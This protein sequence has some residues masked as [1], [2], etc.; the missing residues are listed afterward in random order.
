MTQPFEERC[1]RINFVFFSSQTNQTKTVMASKRKRQATNNETNET[2]DTKMNLFRSQNERY[3][4][5]HRSIDILISNSSAVFVRISSIELSIV[6][7]SFEA[8]SSALFESEHRIE[9]FVFIDTHPIDFLEHVEYRDVD[10]DTE[11]L[12]NRNQTNESIVVDDHSQVSSIDDS[13]ASVVLLLAAHGPDNSMETFVCVCSSTSKDLT[14]TIIATEVFV[15]G[16]DR[17]THSGGKRMTFV[18]VIE[19][20]VE[21][22][23]IRITIIVHRLIISARHVIPRGPGSFFHLHEI[24]VVVSYRLAKIDL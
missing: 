6:S 16:L 5:H 3:A 1:A 17:E 14:K 2:N 23:M 19:I 21:S 8:I 13:L 7:K 24:V 15:S 12:I 20:K 9:R 10:C 11:R 18:L 4:K 22:T